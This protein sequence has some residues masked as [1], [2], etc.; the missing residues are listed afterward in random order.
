M[1]VDARVCE[2]LTVPVQTP[3]VHGFGESVTRVVPVKPPEMTI[4]IVSEPDAT[5]VVA[6]VIDDVLIE[7]V[8]IGAA[9]PDAQ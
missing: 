6:N 2:E 7:P 1:E 5:A 9:N 8:T 4:P 3:V